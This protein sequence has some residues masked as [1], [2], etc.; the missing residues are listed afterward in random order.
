M[1]ADAVAFHAA[2]PGHLAFGELV[3]G[4]GE[5]DVHL[6]VGEFPKH[7]L[8]NE[9]V[10]KA[11]PEEVVGRDA[12]FEEALDFLDEAILEALV[13]AAVDAGDALLAGDEGA[14]VEGLLRQALRRDAVLAV[15]LVRPGGGFDVQAGASAEEMAKDYHVYL[16]IADG[17][18]ELGTEFISLEKYAKDAAEYLRARGIGYVDA[19]YGVSM[20]GA[21]V[22]R[23]LATED[24]PVEKA[25][26]DATLARLRAN[27]PDWWCGYSY[28]WLANMEARAGHGKE[29]AEALRTF[30]GCFVLRNSFHANGDQTKSGKSNY[31]YR[32]FTLEGNFA[33]ASGLQEMLLQSQTGVIEVFPAIPA[34]W[35]DISFNRLRAMGAFLVSAELKDG[36]VVSLN[37]YS[38]KGGTLKIVSPLD[39]SVITRQ[40]S[41]GETV[42]II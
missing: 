17:H 22:I 25:I 4:V 23:F 7:I 5:E 11:V 26:I 14:D 13:Q 29:A 27:G 36:K 15:E 9:L 34:D 12:A 16:F 19:M 18:D 8:R 20:G 28:S 35:K 3:D 6:V 24:I 33:Y 10:F 21:A 42:K 32:P 40:T 38:E 30:A 2:E 1:D 37:V 39:G 41:P 31:T